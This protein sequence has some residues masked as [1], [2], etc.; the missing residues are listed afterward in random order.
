[1]REGVE[2]IVLNLGCILA[3]IKRILRVEKDICL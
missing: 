2:S 1:M 3:T